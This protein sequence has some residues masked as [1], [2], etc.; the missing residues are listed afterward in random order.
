MVSLNDPLGAT[1]ATA[2]SASIDSVAD[3]QD[4]H[5]NLALALPDQGP[6][7]AQALNRREHK[8]LTAP[9]LGWLNLVRLKYG[10]AVSLLDLSAGGAQ[11]EGSGLRLNP[12]ATVV[13]EI[14]GRD[15]GFAV[16]SQV[17]RSQVSRIS[18]CVTYRGALEFKRPIELPG[19]PEPA[20]R[21]P[22]INLL[23]RQAT[24]AAA[25]RRP[26]LSHRQVL[27][28]ARQVLTIGK[29]IGRPLAARTGRGSAGAPA[30]W[31]CLVVRY[32]DGR[33][34]KGYGRDFSPQ[35]GRFQI[36]SSP[37]CPV[38]SRITV[39]LS[40]LKTV[41]FVRHP[42][43]AAG[44]AEP[45]GSAAEPGRRVLV[46]FRDG[47]VL[48]ATTLNYSENGPGFFVTPVER[49]TNNLRIFVLSKAIARVQFP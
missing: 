48:A 21:E 28:T 47:E 13:I 49:Q 26:G 14:A 39:P 34:L 36:W 15:C 46:T 9:E 40:S 7:L 30:G 16:P 41:C 42:D 18:P 35:Q 11:I 44:R 3:R 5:S 4:M 1:L 31:H 33:T 43:G 19:R 20:V 6:G 17:V 32:I 10:P 2:G 8:R 24:L 22:D 27:E 23:R 29:T 12:G 25:L 45:L 37:D 38:E